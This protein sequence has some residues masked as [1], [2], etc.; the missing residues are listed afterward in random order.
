MII[1]DLDV[2]MITD[3]RHLIVLL[4]PLQKNSGTIVV[5]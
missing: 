5:F 1:N 2:M 4:R 3:L